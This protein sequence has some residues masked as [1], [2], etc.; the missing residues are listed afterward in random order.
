MID[1]ALDCTGLPAAPAG[2]RLRAREAFS[3]EISPEF[4]F[5]VPRV[6]V[7]HTRWA[8]VPHVQWQTIICLYAAPS[9]EWV[10]ADGMPGLLDRLICWL[11]QAAAGNLDPDGQPLHPPVA[12]ASPVAGV[13]VVRPDLPVAVSSPV[14]GSA[15]SARLMV[16]VCRQDRRDRADVTEWITPDQWKLRNQAAELSGDLGA[17]G[18]RL[19]GAAA[20]ILTRDIGFE[21]PDK[22]AAL[23]A[24]LE[25]AGE[26]PAA[27]LGL[28]GAVAAINARLDAV[29]TL[30]GHALPARPLCLF[31]GTP[32]RR[33][34]GT[35]HR[36]IHLVCWRLDDIGQKLL[37]TARLSGTDDHQLALATAGWLEQA[38]TTWIA[39]PGG[40]A[41]GQ[42]AGRRGVI[43]KRRAWFRGHIRWPRRSGARR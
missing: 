4:P 27:L 42:R 40:F 31:V 18:N 21:Y 25:V 29:H 6:R 33:A 8:G 1:V 20:I 13:A 36:L 41:A 11:R 32:S 15:S 38:T 9:V 17:D 43:P 7:P 2:L 39:W 3:L 30:Q 24:G 28:F 22:A 16:A 5:T 23:L 10:S 12:Y 34:A 35:G 37:A 26:D 19:L 14:T